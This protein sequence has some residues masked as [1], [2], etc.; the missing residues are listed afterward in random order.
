MWVLI[1]APAIPQTLMLPLLGI[2]LA[3][4]QPQW[5]QPVD[6]SLLH[7]V[8]NGVIVINCDLGMAEATWLMMGVYLVLAVLIVC[9]GRRMFFAKP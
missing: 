1:G 8:Q 7:G 3:G 2:F 9:I 6:G 5:W 4:I